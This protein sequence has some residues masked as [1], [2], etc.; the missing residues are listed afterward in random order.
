MSDVFYI[1]AEILNCI[2]EVLIIFLFYNRILEKKY[3]L[4]IIY[5]IVYMFEFVIFAAAAICIDKPYIRVSITFILLLVSA[6]VLYQNSITKKFFT[7]LYYFLIIFISETLF[8][9]IITLLGYG[10]QAD[11]LNSGAGRIIGMVGTKIFDFW[12][13]IYSCRIYKNKARSLP[14]NYWIQILLM[15]FLSS[16]ILLQIYS[17]DLL[18][19]KEIILYIIT[20]TGILYLNF[21][22]FNYFE[23]YDKQVR[24]TAL[25]QIMEQED[26]NYKALT[27][28]YSEI[29]SIK[30]DLINQVSVLNDLINNTNI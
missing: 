1:M 27:N 5:F 26:R 9:G 14:I 4:S 20:I 11:L 6:I 19:N 7:A 21:S 17:L 10:S 28:S 18:T 24:L 16:A 29:R 30:H 8:M 25:E 13:V 12:I 2:P 23:S 22:V 15:P 3:D